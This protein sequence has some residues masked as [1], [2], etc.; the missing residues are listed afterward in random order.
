V[1]PP[2]RVVEAP[3]PSPLARDRTTGK[4]AILGT[5]PFSRVNDALVALGHA[6]L[7]WRLP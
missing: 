7:D 3:H 4:A 2:H 1:A 5:R 6:P